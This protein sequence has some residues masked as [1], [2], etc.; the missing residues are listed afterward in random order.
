MERDEDRQIESER[1]SEPEIERV[2][3]ARMFGLNVWLV[4]IALMK[5]G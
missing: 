2:R 4:V 1:A 3:D 5:M